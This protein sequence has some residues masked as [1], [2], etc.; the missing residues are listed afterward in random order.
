MI[1]LYRNK[2]QAERSARLDGRIVEADHCVR[3]L[4]WLE[5][6][7]DLGGHA[8]KALEALR[9]GDRTLWEVTATPVSEMLGRIRRETWLEKGE[10][11]RPPPPPPGPRDS[12]CMT[13]PPNGYRVERDGDYH[14]WLRRQETNQRLAA[15]AQRE[16]EEKA[17][18]E[19][20]AWKKRLEEE[21]GGEG[22][23]GDEGE[24][25]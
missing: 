19:A 3:Q 14:E 2:L 13:R 23:E 21:G 12:F 5:V 6:V 17:Q 1:N 18:A 4:S 7:L 22:D 8:I 10:V 20:E 9:C 25:K 15:E 24:G 16:W 11:D